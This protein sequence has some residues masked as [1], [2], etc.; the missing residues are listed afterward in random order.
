MAEDLGVSRMCDGW[1]N[2][3]HLKTPFVQIQTW[4]DFSEDH[5]ITESNYRGETLI[6]LTR[7]FADWYHTGKKPGVK[8]E[9]V[10]LFHHRQ[11]IDAKLTESTILAHNDQWHKAPSSNYL[12]VVTILDKPAN[13]TLSAG[14]KTW[15]NFAPA[16]LH[17]WLVYVPSPKTEPGPLHEAYVRPDNS[18]YPISD[19][20][21][22]VTV[23]DCIPGGV[24]CV[25]IER[26]GQT[27]G[28][29]TSRCALADEGRWQ[30]LAMIGTELFLPHRDNKSDITKTIKHRE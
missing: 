30:D 13:I 3:I 26:N 28:T 14:E 25:R 10:F 20:N 5:N 24:P 23:A 21:R 19:S 11:L 16:G 8:R 7:Y 12:N 29:L 15:T 4:N 9:Q 6:N 1:R 17:E 2:A 18:S 27:I 22:T